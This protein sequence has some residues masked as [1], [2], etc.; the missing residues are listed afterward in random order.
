VTVGKSLISSQDIVC[1]VLGVVIRGWD[2]AVPTMRTGEISL[3]TI[4]PEYAYGQEGSGTKIP[5]NTTL[6]FEIELVHWKGEELTKDGQLTKIIL[7]K[8]EGYEKPNTGA[9]C[10]GK[11]INSCY[12]WLL[13]YMYD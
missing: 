11:P 8:G 12:F 2:I 6:Q 7:E 13:H 10:K 4:K 5:P 3:F 1:Y 9:I